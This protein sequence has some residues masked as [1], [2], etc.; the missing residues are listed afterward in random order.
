[1]G[2]IAGM[3]QKLLTI[4]VAAYNVEKYI[5]KCLESL[6]I[7]EDL[8]E[9]LEVLVVDDGGT[10]N[11]RGIALEF[12]NKYPDVFKA[13]HKDNGGY[14]SVFNWTIKHA[15]GKYFKL[16]DGDDWF[17]KDNFKRFVT[18]LRTIDADIVYSDYAIVKEN[19]EKL[20][21]V[22]EIRDSN[23]NDLYKKNVVKMWAMTF[24]TKLLRDNLIFLPEGRLYT[25]VLLGATPLLYAQTGKKVDS[26][27]YCY[28]I[29]REGQST[30]LGSKI[31]HIADIENLCGIL[32]DTCNVALSKD[33]K[34]ADA[35]EYRT[36]D[37][38]VYYLDVLLLAGR[39]DLFR[40]F[41]K[42]IKNEYPRIYS[43][44]ARKN[45]KG[46]FMVCA[47]MGNYAFLP[48]VKYI[49][50]RMLKVR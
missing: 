13:I 18:S 47:R 7:D 6:I 30:A 31:K 26:C 9:L 5:Y 46:L 45:K 23:F 33:A 40:E 35:I 37:T 10:D 15:S 14:G 42:R 12:E 19:K 34:N 49:R 29:G 44:M 41:D 36:A 8:M 3:G 48:L 43:A 24:R 32:L 20:V 16:L 38:C 22:P 2:L 17:L 4:S 39:A 25:D 21:S 50:E 1:M 28:R 27:V 11:S